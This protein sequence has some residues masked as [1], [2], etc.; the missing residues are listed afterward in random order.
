MKGVRFA[1]SPTGIFHLGNLR[2][3]WV[4]HELSKRLN[5][6]WV[7]RI[8]DIDTARVKSVYKERQLK[9]LHELGLVPDEIVVQSERSETHKEHFE[10]AR[11]EGLVYPCDCSRSDVLQSLK[12]LREASHTIPPEY[13]GNCRDRRD[14]NDLSGYRPVETLAWRWRNSEPTGRHDAIVARSHPD[15]SAFS[16]GYH[17]A[18]AI[19]DAE[20]NYRLLV[21]AWDLAPA[22]R[23]QKEIRQWAGSKQTT[24]FHTA[25]VTQDSGVR[26]EKR[27]RGVT[28]EDVEQKGVTAKALTVAFARGFKFED[29]KLALTTFPQNEDEELGELRRTLSVTEL[30]TPRLPL[31]A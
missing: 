1:P 6:P 12:H 9:D 26:L 4:S 17:W 20:G 29:F 13:S 3:A 19:D 5:E 8:E 27:T 2:T 15:G 21:R 25:L 10:R 23:T 24:V 31:K 30:L 22:E 16:A 11:R 7:L 18:C 28:L 14:Q